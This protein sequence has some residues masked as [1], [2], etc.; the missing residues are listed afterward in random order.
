MA[1]VRFSKQLTEEIVMNA[2]NKMEAAV[3]KARDTKPGDA[4]GQRI[5]DTLFAD[6]RATLATLPV[7]WVQEVTTIKIDK[8]ADQFF[9][10]VFPLGSSRPWPHVFYETDMAVRANS[11]STGIALKAHPLWE[12]FAAEVTAYNT[13]IKVARQ[14]QA[15]FCGMVQKVIE[16]YST[17]A[18][19]LEAWPPLWELIPENVKDKHRQVV[20]REKKS[21]E[22]NV[23][24]GKL[25]ALS[26]AAKFGL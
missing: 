21:V 10:G 13:Q 7:G 9:Q 1:T 4:W 26:T 18:P 12:E 20:E 14:R 24:L 6:V 19:A 23:D 17:L 11:Y 3:A 8:V 2:R 15:E 25:T 16:A 5:Y 22:L